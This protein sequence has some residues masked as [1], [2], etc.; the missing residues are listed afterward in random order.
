M[1]GDD[2]VVPNTTGAEESTE[3]D[4]FT[5]EENQEESMEIDQLINEPLESGKIARCKKCRRMKFGHPLP[6][7]LHD[8]Q[9]DPILDDVELREDD[10]QKNEKRK[11]S[12][13]RKLKPSGG[14]PG[15]TLEKKSKPG[16]PDE[17]VKRLEEERMKLKKILN[18][19]D[20]KKENDQKKMDLVDEIYK[21][22]DK[23]TIND[24]DF[25]KSTNK[26]TLR[27]P[28]N[29]GRY[30]SRE[31]SQDKERDKDRN[32]ASSHDRRRRNNRS[33]ER[34]NKLREDK[35]RKNQQ[36]RTNNKEE[37]G[38]YSREDRR[39]YEERKVQRGYEERRENKNRENDD[40]RREYRNDGRNDNKNRE[41][42]DERRNDGRNDEERRQCR[43]N[44]RDERDSRK[45]HNRQ[46]ENRNN[47][48][49]RESSR[50]SNRSDQSI[51][52]SYQ[53]LTTNVINVVRE[54]ADNRKD[55][56]D[57]PPT[58][59]AEMSI[60][61]WARY[62]RIWN[63]AEVKPYR[64]AQALIEDLKKNDKRKGLKEMV[65]NDIIENQ[66]FDLESVYVVENIISK[67]KDFLQD[68]RWSRTV[69]LA[70]EF[71]KFEQTVN[72]E[73][74]DYISRFSILETKLRN[75]KVGIN[76]TFMAAILLNKSKIVQSEK[77]NILA[78]FD[79]ESENPDELLKRIKKKIRD[80]DA[81]K[82]TAVKETLYEGQGGKYR[83]RSNSKFRGNDYRSK[84]Q[85][86]EEGNRSNSRNRG[87]WKQKGGNRS[88][89]WTR[90]G[91]H[92][93]R[94]K[95][96]GRNGNYGN[97]RF[98]SGDRRKNFQNSRSK[99]TDRK[100]E[101]KRTYKCDK[102]NINTDKSIFE[103]KVENRAV[104]DSGCPE[105]VGGIA[106]LKTYEHSLGKELPRLNKVD[107]FK[108]GDTVY[109]TEMYVRLP[110]ELESLQEYVDVGIVKANVPL[111]I[112]KMKLKEWG[113]IID[114]SE[115]T[116]HLK[117]TNE[118]IK[119]KETESGHLSVNV[120]KTIENNREEVVHEI[121]LIKK[122]KEY[123][124]MKLKKLHR[125]FGHPCH[126]KMELLMKDSG[127]CDKIILKMLKKIQEKCRVCLKFKR[128]A[129]KPKVGFAKAREVNET[130][131]V[132]L[133]PVS[134]LTGDQKDGRQIVYIMD[135]FSRFT[136]AG[137][138]K[139]K[140]AEEVVK[141][142]LNKWCLGMMGY[143]SR[144]FFAD[145]GTEFKGKT[146]E[147]LSRRLGVKVELSPSYSPWS[148]G[149]NERRHGAVNLTVKKL[150]EEDRSLKLD[151]ALQHTI[152]A[153][154]K[155]GNRK[156]WKISK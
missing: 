10:Q 17:E 11:E 60:E 3:E 38:S 14:P 105:M 103:N 51:S 98:S 141:I 89:N 154:K 136:A 2:N 149:G 138:S 101:P 73:N 71:C 67:V 55:K 113:G 95:S 53:E 13:N 74:K 31:R 33:R 32:R 87:E 100:P 18:E 4:V 49:V 93:S 25:I 46:S 126:E 26:K 85:F 70:D 30:G 61:A 84:S 57:P 107:Y 128:K 124:M 123:S 143:P 109:K 155:H 27:K 148:N 24:D 122:K 65:V 77:N 6:Y 63:K 142:I 119:L 106:W 111:L 131:S 8:C 36:Q 152:W 7:G 54:I 47:H 96:R 78:N 145:N 50:V 134:S 112:S 23:V 56:L 22:K 127:E 92:R 144:S 41:N 104:L 42:Y 94:S 79:L 72:E 52:S 125:I 150:M 20:K 117:A 59:D 130:V 80:I 82:R 110:L 99:S 28:E 90:N 34:S 40:E 21:L 114:F 156:T 75:E 121:L 37:R 102:F 151:D 43:D 69:I 39:C 146:L 81:T 86:R 76:S 135:E 132:D 44:R 68:S 140:E 147:H 62:V 137:I 15:T 5:I 83:G 64:K 97:Q 9:L 108:F 118:T 1:G 16:N 58:W 129:S 116:L 91:D 88:G 120:G 45:D 66:E 153:S 133:K 48:N 12:R 29:V 115:N 19:Q 139:N 35:E